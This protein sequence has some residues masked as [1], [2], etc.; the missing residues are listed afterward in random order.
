[1]ITEEETKVPKAHFVTDEQLKTV[2]QTLLFV[3]FFNIWYGAV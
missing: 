1:M 2:T 3:W